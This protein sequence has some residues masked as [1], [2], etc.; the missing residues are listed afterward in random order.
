VNAE[1]I[2][3]GRGKCFSLRSDLNGELSGGSDDESSGVAIAE[4]LN[5]RLSGQGFEAGF[6]GRREEGDRLSGS[7]SSLEA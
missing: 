6:D 3:L 5:V 2:R 1:L 4:A 7:G